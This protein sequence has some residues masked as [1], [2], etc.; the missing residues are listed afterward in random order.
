MRNRIFVSST[1]MAAGL[2]LAGCGSGGSGY[3]PTP[4]KPVDVAAVKPSDETSLM[5][6]SVGNQWTY[7]GQTGIRVQGKSQTQDFELTFKVVKVTPSA[8]GKIADIEIVSNLPN[9]KTDRQRWEVNSKGIYQLAIGNPLVAFDPPQPVIL[10]PADAE[11]KFSWK[12]KGI[13]PAGK[14]GSTTAES[15]ILAPQIV[16]SA[17]E[18]VSAIPVETKGTL[19]VN[20]TKGQY[21]AMAWWAP[22][23]GLVRY[24]Q[25]VV[26]ANQNVLVQILKLK[27]K[28]VQ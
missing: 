22:K 18:S 19:D 2:L 8:N 10:F 25:E 28:T 15:R 17:S 26:I 11:R 14:Q 5:P 23:I 20:N 7:T 27:A 16:D 6:L 21:L 1:A 13:T 9:A 12:G 24:R 3:K 4:S